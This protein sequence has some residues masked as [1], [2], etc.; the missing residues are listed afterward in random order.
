MKNLITLLIVLVSSL[1]IVGQ[2]IGEKTVDFSKIKVG[3]VISDYQGFKYKKI[4]EE[5]VIDTSIGLGQADIWERV[6]PTDKNKW[7][8]P[9]LNNKANVS[10]DITFVWIYRADDEETPRF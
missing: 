5:K 2:S 9:S 10:H 6:E 7:Y 1:V 3:E 4:T 8:T